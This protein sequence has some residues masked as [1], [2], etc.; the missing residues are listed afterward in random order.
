MC[1]CLLVWADGQQT[2][3]C[4]IRMA[5]FHYRLLNDFPI[6]IEITTII[7]SSE[8]NVWRLSIQILRKQSCIFAYFKT[9]VDSSHSRKMSPVI[10][11]TFWLK[12]HIFTSPR[13]FFIVFAYRLHRLSSS[14]YKLD[15]EP[16]WMSIPH[17]EM[18]QDCKSIA[19][20]WTIASC[21]SRNPEDALDTNHPV[22]VIILPE[23]VLLI[24]LCVSQHCETLSNHCG[25]TE[26]RII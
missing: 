1:V 2:D 4:A 5:R 10:P 19:A 21:S 17:S 15:T 20:C 26:T 7:C 3:L 23:C 6:E 25:L 8:P 14:R 12:N 18:S 16:E 11:H 24:C 13:S 22:P 9:D